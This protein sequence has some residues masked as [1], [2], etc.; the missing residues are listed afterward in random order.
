MTKDPKTKYNMLNLKVI[1]YVV[2]ILLL[3]QQRNQ[4]K[5]RTRRKF[6]RYLSKAKSPYERIINENI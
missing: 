2:P 5:I 4:S 3:E 6:N 1:H